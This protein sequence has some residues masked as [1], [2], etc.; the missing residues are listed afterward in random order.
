MSR[1]FPFLG[2]ALQPFPQ[3]LAELPKGMSKRLTTHLSNANY[4]VRLLRYWWAGQALL[5]ESRRQG[6][7]LTVVD[8]GCE[9]GWL[10]HFTPK[11][12]VERWIGLDWN[13]QQE[14]KE[15]ARY[16]EVHQA[17]FD[18][19]LP[20][21]SAV[22]DAV[23]SL[24]VFEHLP[25]PGSTM[26]EVS[27]LLKPGGVFLGG[28]P[29]MPHWLARLRES[30]FRQ[31]LKRGLIAV[32]GHITVLSPKRW[33]NLATDSGLEVEF[34]TGSHLIR[35]TSS[36]LENSR[37]WVRLNQVWGALF[38]SLGSEC[39]V[40]ARR[41]ALWQA[42]PARLERADPHWRGL[43][44]GAGC[45]ALALVFGAVVAVTSYLRQTDQQRLLAWVDAH[46]QGKDMFVLAE[47][48]LVPISAGRE[49]T[50]VARSMHEL[51]ALSAEHPHAH[52]VVS[53][54]TAQAFAESH[55]SHGWGV[56]SRLDMEDVDYVMLKKQPQVTPLKHYLSGVAGDA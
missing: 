54:D 6:R 11:G 19:P 40:K 50:V 33:I 14:V 31:R 25:R 20:V 44:V 55:D 10:K 17:N 51:V 27:R 15:Q 18:E 36:R 22:A 8:L 35:L 32:G 3:L 34:A 53:V 21:P 30:Y 13:I 45:A 23:V 29:T 37:W 46:Q 1:R 41:G 7:A 2:Y 26:S 38:P 48:D 5:E 9:R 43:W 47:N 12:A 39:Y 4:S 24:H 42:K 28:A 56:D 49:D 52:V 16:D